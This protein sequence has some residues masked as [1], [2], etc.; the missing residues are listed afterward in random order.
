MVASACISILCFFAIRCIFYRHLGE[1][2]LLNHPRN[3]EIKY[4]FSLVCAFGRKSKLYH[5]DRKCFQVFHLYLL[6]I[7]VCGTYGRDL[8]G[9]TT[10][11]K[12]IQNAHLYSNV[13]WIQI[14]TVDSSVGKLPVWQKSRD[15]M[16][17]TTT[18][19]P[20]SFWAIR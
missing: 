20:F 11:W 12:A 14:C 7:F 17:L 4:D 18:L 10:P 19:Y 2:W 13:M 1:L 6:V 3:M 15:G 16:S 5:F 8:Y 9:A